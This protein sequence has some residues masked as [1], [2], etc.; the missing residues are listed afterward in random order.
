[1]EFCTISTHAQKFSYGW[2]VLEKMYLKKVNEKD[3][4]IENEFLH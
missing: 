4:S 3:S 2:K 1:M